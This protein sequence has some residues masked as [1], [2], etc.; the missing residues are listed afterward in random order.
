[1]ATAEM[2]KFGQGLM[3]L[4]TDIMAF[5]AD[6]QSH[7]PQ[8]PSPPDAKDTQTRFY[9]FEKYPQE[10]LSLF[11]ERFS[12]RVTSDIAR[13]QELGITSPWGLLISDEPRA[14]GKWFGAMG[15]FLTNNDLQGAVRTAADNKLWWTI[16]NGP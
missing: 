1:M 5:A 7:E 6:R 10:T 14:Y 3:D 2:Q 4:S 11:H 12:G 8:W 13:L 9:E 16:F 15:H